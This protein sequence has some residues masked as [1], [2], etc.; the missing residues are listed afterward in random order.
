[1]ASLRQGDRVVVKNDEVYHRW[2]YR[3][4]HT[5]LGVILAETPHGEYVVLLVDGRELYFKREEI[6]RV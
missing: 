3:P 4:T 6:D 2:G 1:M 5:M